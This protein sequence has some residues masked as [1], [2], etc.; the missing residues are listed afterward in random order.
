MFSRFMH[1]VAGVRTSF[2]FIAKWYSRV[3]I[4]HIL[5]ILGQIDGHSAVPTFRCSE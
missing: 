1:V 4:D 2:L 3:W 5:F